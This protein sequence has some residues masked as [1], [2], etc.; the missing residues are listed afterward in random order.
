[1]MRAFRRDDDNTNNHP[2]NRGRDKTIS[3]RMAEGGVEP[4]RAAT[5][6]RRV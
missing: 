4:P 6:N 5:P 1:M 2:D 3:P